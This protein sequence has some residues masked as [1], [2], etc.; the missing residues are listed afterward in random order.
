MCVKV[1]K[2]SKNN[3]NSQNYNSDDLR[4]GLYMLMGLEAEQ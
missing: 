1:W 4:G 3:K 2:A